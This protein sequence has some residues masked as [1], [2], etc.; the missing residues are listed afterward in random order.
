V[1]SYYRVT[2]NSFAVFFAAF[3]R[4]HRALCAAAIFLRA[5]GERV[6]LRRIG[7]T[8]AFSRTLAQRALWAE[9]IRARADAESFRLPVPFTYALPK[10]AGAAVMP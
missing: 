10:A 2:P 6:R 8:F 4:A 3:T 5:A 9:A 7:T 1:R